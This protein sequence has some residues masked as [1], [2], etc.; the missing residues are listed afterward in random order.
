MILSSSFWPLF[1]A[2]VGGGFLLTVPLTLLAGGLPGRRTRPQPPALAASPE[3]RDG[4]D[5]SPADEEP[6]R[7]AA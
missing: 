4:G 1:W 6:I 3:P 2:L 5:T 7:R